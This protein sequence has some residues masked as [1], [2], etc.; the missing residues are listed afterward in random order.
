MHYTTFDFLGQYLQGDAFC[1]YLRIRKRFFVDKLGWNIPHDDEVEMD[2][3]DNPCA[4][5]ALVLRDTTV[6]G[7]ARVMPTTASWGRHTYMLRDALRGDPDPAARRRRGIHHERGL[8]MHAARRV[9]RTFL[10]GRPGGVPVAD[11]ERGRPGRPGAWGQRTD[12][13]LAGAARPDA[14]PARLSG[15]PGGRILLRGGRSQLCDA[16]DAGLRARPCHR[17]R[18]IRAIAVADGGPPV[19]T[20]RFPWRTAPAKLPEWAATRG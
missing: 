14:A 11:A 2:Q 17:G 18:M 6:V 9:G 12:L 8:G 19:Q 15:A 1:Q 7:G 20:D 5:Y 16:A 13:A 10:P 3:Y 4:H